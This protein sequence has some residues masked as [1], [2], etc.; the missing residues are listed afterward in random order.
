MISPYLLH[1]KRIVD[2][3]LQH[4]F[5]VCSLFNHN[6]FLKCSNSVSSP[7]GRQPMCNH[8]SGTSS[9]SLAEKQQQFTLKRA[10]LWLKQIK[11]ILGIYNTKK[12]KQKKKYI[13]IYF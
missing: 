9:P 13:Q 7:D 8:N 4:E 6:A 10:Q 1:Y 12:S 2:S 5:A 3:L 11:V